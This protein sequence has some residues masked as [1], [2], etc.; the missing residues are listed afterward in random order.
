[1][2]M[3]AST[4]VN[5]V[6]TRTVKAPVISTSAVFSS[7]ASLPPRAQREMVPRFP[8]VS[9]EYVGTLSNS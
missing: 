4:H 5:R 1:M 7:Q 8:A 9:F 6:F 2:V 3:L